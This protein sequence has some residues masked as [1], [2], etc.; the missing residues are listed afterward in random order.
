MVTYW[1]MAK[2]FLLKFKKSLVHPL[3]GPCAAKKL[4]IPN[5][6]MVVVGHQ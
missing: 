4:L 3:R 5:R 2:Y 6:N 1:Q